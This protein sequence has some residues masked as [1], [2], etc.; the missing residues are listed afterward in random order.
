LQYAVGFQDFKDFI[1]S[2]V[3]VIR[4]T[5]NATRH[6]DPTEELMG[7][8]QEGFDLCDSIMREYCE[9]R[10]KE[11]ADPTDPSA[12]L[13]REE[14]SLLGRTDR[15]G[16][17]KPTESAQDDQPA[18]G[19]ELPQNFASLSIKDASAKPAS[20]NAGPSTPI[21]S[22]LRPRQNINYRE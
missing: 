12:H 1:E 13:P 5:Q 21:K 19:Q 14:K 11:T 8:E 6:L 2:L 17:S 4:R 7:R 10:K 20:P 18:R 16:K 3:V 22:K 15:T 9:L